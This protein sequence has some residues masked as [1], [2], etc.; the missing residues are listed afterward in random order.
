MPSRNPKPI[1]VKRLNQYFKPRRARKRTPIAVKRR[2]HVAA[3]SK[4]RVRTRLERVKRRDGQTQ[5]EVIVEI[6]GVRAGVRA[7]PPASSNQLYC[8]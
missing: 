1:S 5:W 3:N 8:E 4:P 2:F 6:N 7:L